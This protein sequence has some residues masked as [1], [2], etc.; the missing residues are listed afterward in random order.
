[1]DL[2]LLH[3][4]PLFSGLSDKA[5]ERLASATSR[6][7]YTKDTPVVEENELGDSLY[8]ILTGKVKVTNIGPDGKEVILSVLSTGEFFG[9]MSLLDQEPRS[10]NVVTMEK[11]EMM[12]LRRKEFLNLLETNQEILSKLLGVLSGRLR[13]ANAQIRSLALLDVLGRI[14][15]LLL[16]TAR[17]EGRRLLDGSTVFRRPT[18]QEIASMVGT[19]RETVSRMIGDLSRDGF[20]KISGKD[21]IIKEKMEEAFPSQ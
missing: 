5:L 2:Q 19:S 4:V 13:H 17:K 15:R 1:M 7:S 18:H 8:M 6:K 16:D 14:A 9:E 21:I 20:I 12:L 10:A 11:T 3:K